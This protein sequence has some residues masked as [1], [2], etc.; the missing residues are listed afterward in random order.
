MTTP[1]NFFDNAFYIEYSGDDEAKLLKKICGAEGPRFVKVYE[2][3]SWDALATKRIGAEPV[4]SGENFE[5]FES[6]YPDLVDTDE[7]F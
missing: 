5:Q 2:D 6:R 1:R 7:D 4:D 3:G